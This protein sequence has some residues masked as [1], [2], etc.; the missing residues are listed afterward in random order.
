MEKNIM[1]VSAA[2]RGFTLIELSIV[3]VI[4]GL[5]IGGVLTGR[6]L[7][8]SAEIRATVSQIEKYNT[9]AHTFRSKYGGLP[10]DLDIS[11]ASQYGFYY[12][13]NIDHC[14]STL[15]AG[16]NNGIIEEGGCVQWGEDLMF[17]N[18]LAA[19]KLIE[20]N[21]P[22]DDM[23]AFNSWGLFGN[24]YAADDLAY[25]NDIRFFLP[26]TKVGNA[27]STYIFSQSGANYFGIMGLTRL[28]MTSN[29]VYDGLNALTPSQTKAIDSKMD[30]GLPMSGIVRA[31]FSNGYSVTAGSTPSPGNG[32]NAA[33]TVGGCTLTGPPV[34]YDTGPLAA[35]VAGCG[36]SIKFN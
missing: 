33:D 20:G 4:I 11:L 24:A 27:N 26:P 25:G 35:N 17:W 21:F 8:R 16:D 28:A 7:I 31:L 32:Q 22:L 34:I 1:S 2:P 36:L 5:I 6:D 29:L 9:A 3:L 19:A 12:A 15:G 30:D 10:G 23:V 18:H 14:P 13:T